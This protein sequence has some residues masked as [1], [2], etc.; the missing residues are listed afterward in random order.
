MQKWEYV[1]LNVGEQKVIT[2]NGK[3][4]AKLGLLSTTGPVL[5]EYLNQMGPEGWEVV[6]MVGENISIYS[7]VLKRP[8]I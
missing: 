6:G 2:V 3:Q 5:H 8:L 4:V 1:I 7:V